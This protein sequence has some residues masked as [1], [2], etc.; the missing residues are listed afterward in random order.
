MPH[1]VDISSSMIYGSMIPIF[2]YLGKDRVYDAKLSKEAKRR[3]RIIDFYYTKANRNASLTCRHFCISRSY[4]YKWKNRFN[5]KYLGTM[6]SLSRRPKHLREVKYSQSLIN[7]IKEYRKNPDTC[8]YSAKKLASIFWTE[9]T[10]EEYHVSPATIGRIIKRFNYYFHPYITIKR[11]SLVAKRHWNEYKKRKPAGLKATGPR[12]IIEFDMKH[13]I[14]HGRKYYLMCAID[15]YTKEAVIHATTNCSS[16]QGKIVLE[17]AIN[18]FGDKVSILNDNGSENL[19][20]ASE[21]LEDKRIVQ[22]F[23]HPYSPKEKGVIERFIGS[24]DRECLTVHRQD[25]HSL[26]DLEYYVNRWLNNYHF[27]RPHFSLI[28][29]QNKHKK[30]YI[31]YTPAEF[32]ATMGITIDLRKVSTM[33]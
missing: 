21:Y 32:C 16:K 28:N 7:L 24:L 19:G 12:Q 6:E 1:K 22:Y 29:K 23:A 17:K 10:N 25:V 30:K 11:N 8:C 9:Y 18:T 14:A 3:L 20:K 13:F 4:F 33:C 5:P 31:L 27:M 2:K 26:E 15:Q